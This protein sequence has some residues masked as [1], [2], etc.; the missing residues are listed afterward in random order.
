MKIAIIA[1]LVERSHGK[2][3][4]GLDVDVLAYLSEKVKG[5][6]LFQYKTGR[7]VNILIKPS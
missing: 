2:K 4:V 1:Q 3:E 6:P 7:R 5:Q